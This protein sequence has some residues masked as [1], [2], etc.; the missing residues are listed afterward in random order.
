MNYEIVAVGYLLKKQVN[1]S[2][3]K[4]ENI[5]NLSIA[6][7][8]DASIRAAIL[9]GGSVDAIRDSIF[10][11]FRQGNNHVEELKNSIEYRSEYF[12]YGDPE[13]VARI[14]QL[15]EDPQFDRWLDEMVISDIKGSVPASQN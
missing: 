14:R 11:G 10:K 8:V 15:E 5:R 3:D 6:A 4:A 2:S 13:S 1:I 12:Q 9:G 7:Q